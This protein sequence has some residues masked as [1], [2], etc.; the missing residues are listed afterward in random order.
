MAKKMN[1]LTKLRVRMIMSM[2]SLAAAIT[3][4][5]YVTYAWF[6]FSRSQNLDLMAVSVE[7]ELTYS[8]KYFVH[9]GEEGYA[10]PDFSG[11]D[12]NTTVTN[13]GT[14]FAPVSSNYHEVALPIKQPHYRLTYALEVFME[15][16]AL[17]QTLEIALTD[18]SAPPSP[19]FYNVSTNEAIS[20]AE[21]INIYTTVIDGNLSSVDKTLAAKNFVEASTPSSDKFDGT[22]G[23]KLLASSPLTISSE[24]QSRIIFLTL[25]FSGDSSTF[26]KYNSQDNGIVYFDKLTSGN[27]NV[28]QG[29]QFVINSI[30]IAKN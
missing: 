30:S 8:F 3:S 1:H 5:G 10:G 14:Q 25:E 20:L 15:E 13:Y 17:A 16:V 29:L 28:Y 9:N 18:F 7:G 22:E 23:A 27:S 19:Y 4:L 26:Y 24:P 6:Q 12:T 11:T 21:A 2:V